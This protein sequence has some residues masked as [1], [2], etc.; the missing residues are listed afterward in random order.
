MSRTGSNTHI[1][2]SFHFLAPLFTFQ[3]TYIFDAFSV[4]HISIILKAAHANVQMSTCKLCTSLTFPT[5]F[6]NLIL[7][8]RRRILFLLLLHS[9]LSC[10]HSP[11][12]INSNLLLFCCTKAFSFPFSSPAPSFVPLVCLNL[13]PADCRPTYLHFPCQGWLVRAEGK[14]REEQRVAKIKG[15]RPLP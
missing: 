15:S 13:P 1:L 10:F 6:H 9:L 14:R 12:L 4:G 11:V 5:D 8:K 2:C 7:K 3:H